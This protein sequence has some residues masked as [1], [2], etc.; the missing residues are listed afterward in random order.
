[1]KKL[2][3]TTKD[4][5]REES[6]LAKAIALA[7]DIIIPYYPDKDVVRVAKKFPT[8]LNTERFVELCLAK[9]GGYNYVDE[10]GRDFDD[11]YNSDA[12]TCTVNVNNHRAAIQ[13][14]QTKIGSL[15]VVCYNMPK[16]RCDFFYL[17]KDDV[18]LEKEPCYGKEG[19]AGKERIQFS[20]S[21]QYH[22]SYGKFDR[23][24]IKDFVSLAMAKG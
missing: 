19:A 21:K 20:A 2:N 9:I 23:Y 8:L 6:E 18:E 11:K 5:Q 10:E 14:V 13:G 24:R 12:K 4:K 1:M 22:N 7:R 15:R 17:T 3:Q 16:D